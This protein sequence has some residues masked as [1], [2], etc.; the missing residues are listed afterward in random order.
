M[1]KWHPLLFLFMIWK[2]KCNSS[3]YLCRDDQEITRKLIHNLLKVKLSIV[4][5]IR[6]GVKINLNRCCMVSVVKTII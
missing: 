2:E 6:N 3:Y 1:Y 4:N 5:N